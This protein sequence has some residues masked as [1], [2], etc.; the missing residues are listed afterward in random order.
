MATFEREIFI[1]FQ[2]HL[3]TAF[4]RRI[5]DM[6]HT[7]QKPFDFELF[8]KGY[9]FALEAK[10]QRSHLDFRRIKPHQFDH[11]RRVEENGGYSFF[12]VRIEDPK[13]SMDKFRA[14]VISLDRMEE[15][16]REIPKASCNAGDLRTWAEMEA[17][18]VRLSPDRYCWNFPVFFE[19]FVRTG[20]C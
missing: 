5:Y 6:R 13:K 9:F 8:Y 18:R 7:P 1:A 10:Q 16:I 4:F 14:F 17:E 20:G 11:L 19:E 2:D 15:M 3:P 12:L